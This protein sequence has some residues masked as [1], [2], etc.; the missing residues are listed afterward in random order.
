MCPGT[1]AEENEDGREDEEDKD[2]GGGGSFGGD[3]ALWF[4]GVELDWNL[5]LQFWYLL[6]V[7]DWRLWA[8]C[9]AFFPFTFCFVFAIGEVS[10][11]LLALAAT[12]ACRLLSGLRAM[13][14][15]H[16][17]GTVSPNKSIL[18]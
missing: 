16:P 17:S 14:D 1:L 6:G 4:M 9:R 12:A 5:L 7:G 15:S 2:G 3:G 8:R 18:F 11:Q 10:S 13:L